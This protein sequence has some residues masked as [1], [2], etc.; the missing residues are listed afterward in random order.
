MAGRIKSAKKCLEAGYPV[1]FHFD[2][3]I[4]YSG[5]DKDYKEVIDLI[6]SE[7]D[8]EDIA[9]I[10]LG[11]LRYPP[12][13]K[14]IIE[15]RFP[16]SQITWEELGAGEDGKM[17]YSKQIR[18]EIFKRMQAF[19]RSHSKDV[20]VYLCMESIDVWKGSGIQNHE[21]NPYQGYFNF[22]RK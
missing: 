18:I 9:W 13:L 14:D 16:H 15:G 11:A 2:P 19:I 1:A 6:F 5:W 7:I 21:D 17:R 22:F 20:Y 12:E 4:F 8:P 10:S 3:V